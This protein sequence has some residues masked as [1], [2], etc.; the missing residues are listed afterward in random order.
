MKQNICEFALKTF[1]NSD[2]SPEYVYFRQVHRRR[3]KICY[4]AN[5]KLIWTKQNSLPF[6]SCICTKLLKLC[7]A[8]AKLYWPCESTYDRQKQKN[9]NNYYVEAKKRR[10]RCHSNYTDIEKERK[11]AMDWGTHFFLFTLVCEPNKMRAFPL[12][13]VAAIC[14]MTAST[15]YAELQPCFVSNSIQIA[16]PSKT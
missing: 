10:M 16:P 1:F 15:V 11:N 5:S 9:K 13:R 2:I 12:T 4:S 8:R 14:I 3:K 6:F 7:W